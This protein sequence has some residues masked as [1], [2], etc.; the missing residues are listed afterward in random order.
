M[1]EHLQH[2]FY[3]KNDMTM[4]DKVSIIN[5][6]KELSY[7]WWV[8]KLDCS[9]SWM[10]QKIDMSFEEVMEMFMPNCHFT[11]IHRRGIGDWHGE[12]GFSTMGVG[13]E[14]FLWIYVSE[15]DLQK[16]VKEFK[17]ESNG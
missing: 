17:L 3:E 6:A 1:R 15:G 9:E 4:E 8:D 14:H 11:V 13:V 7:E 10:R 2:I 12:I 5:R 16:I